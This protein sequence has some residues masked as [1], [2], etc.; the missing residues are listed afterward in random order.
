MKPSVTTTD[1][2]LFLVLCFKK[3][4]KALIDKKS[5]IEVEELAVLVG[6]VHKEQTVHR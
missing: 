3:H 6:L 4:S 5:K 2:F 1:G